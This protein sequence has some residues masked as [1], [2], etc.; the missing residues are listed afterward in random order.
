MKHPKQTASHTLG[1]WE[2]SDDGEHIIGCADQDEIFEVADLS[3]TLNH[4][5]NARLIAACPEMYEMLRMFRSYLLVLPPPSDVNSPLT[6]IE[7]LIARIEG[8]E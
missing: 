1:P 6:N 7:S 5:A 8:R 4:D 3:N 2:L